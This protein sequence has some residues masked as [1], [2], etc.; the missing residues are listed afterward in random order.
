MSFIKLL[1]TSGIG[2]ESEYWHISE[3]KIDYNVNHVLLRIV[4]YKTK[5]DKENGSKPT[6]KIDYN[7]TNWIE[8]VTETNGDIIEIEHNDYDTFMSQGLDNKIE[9]QLKKHIRTIDKNDILSDS[10]DG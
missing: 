4:G 9:V 3:V 1:D 10:T 5:T 8:T 7:V 6:G 2:F